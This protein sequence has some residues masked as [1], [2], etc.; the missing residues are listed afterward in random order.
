MLQ[1][2]TGDIYYF[3]RSIATF[4]WNSTGEIGRIGPKYIVTSRSGFSVRCRPM[5]PI[6]PVEFQL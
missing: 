1:I 5:S 4:S 6:F 3:V 2:C